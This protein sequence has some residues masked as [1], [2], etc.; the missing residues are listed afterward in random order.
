MAFVKESANAIFSNYY[1]L[2]CK[3]CVHNVIAS[4]LIC[5]LLHSRTI[6]RYPVAGNSTVRTVE[7]EDFK[8]ASGNMISYVPP[9][10]TLHMH[11]YS[12]HNTTREWEKPKE[13]LPDRWIEL[14][15]SSISTGEEGQSDEPEPTFPKCPFMSTATQSEALSSLT[16]L[17]AY[18]GV[19]FDPD[20]LSF[21]PFSAGHRS[22]PGKGLVL[23]AL[24][25]VVAALVVSYR[26]DPAE[27]F[28]D[29]DTGISQ[30]AII[31]PLLPMSTKVKVTRAVD[32][33]KVPKKKIDDGWADDEGDDSKIANDGVETSGDGSE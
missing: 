4:E 7:T 10:I 20:S 33:G 16:S 17:A 30:D 23:D 27:P 26:L 1:S 22:C 9:N 8:L 11:M 24:R 12:L 25:R 3:Y 28:D 15:P 6:G 21:F 31:I 32:L 2:L 13:F 29:E 19:G 14:D 5:V 18:E